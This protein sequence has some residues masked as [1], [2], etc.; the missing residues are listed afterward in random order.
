MLA[1]V[2][3]LTLVALAAIVTAALLAREFIRYLLDERED[4]LTQHR[5]DLAML[6][7]QLAGE[8]RDTLDCLGEERAAFLD[9]LRGAAHEAASERHNLME[10]VQRPEHEPAPPDF[11][12]PDLDLNRT[13]DDEIAEARAAAIALFDAERAAREELGIA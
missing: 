3:A 4:A 7:E 11:D 5:L 1:I 12:G 9:A 13:E 2:I 10:R 8:R 6:Q